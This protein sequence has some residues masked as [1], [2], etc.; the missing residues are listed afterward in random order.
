MKYDNCQH[1]LISAL[2]AYFWWGC[3]AA[4]RPRTPTNRLTRVGITLEVGPGGGQCPPPEQI[5]L[6]VVLAALP[7]GRPPEK[8]LGVIC[9]EI[10]R[11]LPACL[12]SS[13]SPCSFVWP[14]GSSLSSAACTP[15][16]CAAICIATFRRGWIGAWS[17]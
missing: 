16:A 5:F 3:G 15:S 12:G 9:A 10:N 1:L 4:K 7:P 11:R 14:R 17:S 8:A 6:V 2:V 13:G